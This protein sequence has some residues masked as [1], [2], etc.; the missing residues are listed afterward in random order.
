MALTACSCWYASAIS[1]QSPLWWLVG[2]GEGGDDN[3]E[4]DIEE[5]GEDGEVRR[6]WS[7][8]TRLAEHRE[9]IAEREREEAE[10]KKKSTESK[11]NIYIW[12]D[13]VHRLIYNAHAFV[14]SY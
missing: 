10:R 8:A 5:I 7:P 6:K 2:I 13:L 4:E 12:S 11:S 1:I 3:D 14:L 9:E